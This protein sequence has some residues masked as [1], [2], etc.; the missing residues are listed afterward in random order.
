MCIRFINKGG[1]DTSDA[2]A[3]ASDILKDKTAYADG[4]KLTGTLEP[5]S[6]F[7]PDWSQIGYSNTPKFIIND[8]NYSK[9]IYDNWD[10]SVTNLGRKFFQNK[11]LI[12]MPLVDTSNATKTDNMFFECTLLKYVPLLDTSK[13]T[14]M[15]QMFKSCSNLIE[16]SLLDTSNVSNMSNMFNDCGSLK[17]VPAFNTQNA[18]DISY[19]FSSC[20]S[21][22]EIPLLNTS[23]VTNMTYLCGSCTN[24]TTVPVLDTSKV[25]NM[26]AM[27]IFDKKLSTNSL[28]N[29]LQMC[30]NATSFTGTKT[31]V[32]LGLSKSNYPAS[33]IE[34]LSNY[35]AFIDA[36]WTTGY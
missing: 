23:N 16:I 27:F 8:F 36:G 26:S 17:S 1:I 10:S 12:Y 5:G 30:I 21:I 31:L 13:V 34:S 11:Q 20:S 6:S 29:I 19:M 32:Y 35:Q 25:T 14:S 4:V 7:P 28:N 3:T 24:L 22:Q 15:Y 33:I 18:T 2:T 9:E